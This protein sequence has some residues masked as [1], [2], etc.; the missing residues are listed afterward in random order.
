MSVKRGRFG[1]EDVAYIQANMGRMSAESLGERLQRSPEKVQEVI[2]KLRREK[3]ERPQEDVE[4]LSIRKELKESQAWRVLRKEFE[5]DELAFFEECYL[6]HMMTYKG[7]VLAPEETQIFH[8]AKYEILM[9][10]NLQDRTQAIKERK[11]LERQL[12]ELTSQFHSPQEMDE[13]D[14]G[15]LLMLDSQ[16]KTEKA[17]EMQK[18]NEYT[19]LQK[20]HASLMKDLKATRDQRIKNIETKQNFTDLLRALQDRDAQLEEGRMLALTSLAGEKAL[21]DLGM[22]AEYEDG[23]VDRPILSAA[24][25]DLEPE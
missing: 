14:R 9:S 13:D 16:I 2:D 6:K 25:I 1:K 21:H 3:P 23:T 8:L 4:K 5:P 18:T 10:R 20:Q 11:K 22:E 17:A 24:T 15:A 19:N 12:A 7:D